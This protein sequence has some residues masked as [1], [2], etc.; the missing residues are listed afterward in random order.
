MTLE[1]KIVNMAADRTALFKASIKTVRTRNKA[2]GV[3]KDSSKSTLLSH[4][5]KMKDDFAIKAKEVVS[6]FGPVPAEIESKP[7]QRFG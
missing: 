6:I 2:L 4:A 3:A 5:Q 1:M 7:R